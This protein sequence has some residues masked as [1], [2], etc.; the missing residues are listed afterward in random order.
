MVN[1]DKIDGHRVGNDLY[2]GPG[3]MGLEGSIGIF[4][5]ERGGWE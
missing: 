5:T 2:R 4:Y 1:V 3:W